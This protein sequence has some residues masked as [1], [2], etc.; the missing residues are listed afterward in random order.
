M[1]VKPLELNE[2][3]RC[4]K[5][6]KQTAH[7][8]ERAYIFDRGLQIVKRTKYKDGV[9]LP[10]IVYNDYRCLECGF[11][12]TITAKMPKSEKFVFR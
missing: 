7:V 9:R 3:F 10:K 2:V 8:F 12:L 4:K 1:S 11:I 5:C 6:K